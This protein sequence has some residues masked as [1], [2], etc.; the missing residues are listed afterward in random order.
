MDET[1]P[2]TP[3]ETPSE[4]TELLSKYRYMLRVT[5]DDDVSL[6]PYGAN[7]FTNAMAYMTGEVLCEAAPPKY[8]GYV[9]AQCLEVIIHAA[10]GRNM[11]GWGCVNAYLLKRVI[12]AAKTDDYTKAEFL[13]AVAKL[14]DSPNTDPDADS[15][16]GETI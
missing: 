14:W 10:V 6:S 1:P 11:E 7:A 3:P 5:Y 12:Q 4:F 8:I 16:F 9:V 13:D 2:E 15:E